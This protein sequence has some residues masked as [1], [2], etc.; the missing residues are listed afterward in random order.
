MVR[1]PTTQDSNLAYHAAGLL[2]LEC[3]EV[4]L[5]INE[6]YRE[7]GRQAKSEIWC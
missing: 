7:R 6:C 2:L 3:F 4:Y 5:R 1:Y